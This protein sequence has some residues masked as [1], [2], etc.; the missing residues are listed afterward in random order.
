MGIA[1]VALNSRGKNK[2]DKLKQMVERIS[3]ANQ[4]IKISDVFETQDKNGVALGSFLSC[5]LEVETDMQGHQFFKF[6]SENR[7]QINDEAQSAHTHVTK[8][9]E[10]DLVDF[11]G[12][13][14]RTPQ[15]TIPHPE[16]HMK[17]YIIIPLA[18]MEPDWKHPILKKPASELAQQAFWPGWGSFFVQGKTLLDF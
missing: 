9:I 4:I 14:A 15:L 8:V 1:I 17:A 3:F 10:F 11:R 16:A 13:T 12:E 18:E 6:L 7:D 5:C 2:L